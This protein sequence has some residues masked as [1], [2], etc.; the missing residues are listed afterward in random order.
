MA[1]VNKGDDEQ[2]SERAGSPVMRQV[3][4]SDR[5]KNCA[6]RAK[7]SG[8]FSASQSSFGVS[9]SGEMRPPT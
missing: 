7:A 3:R 9:I 5:S 8:I 1:F 2:Q 6:V 4:K